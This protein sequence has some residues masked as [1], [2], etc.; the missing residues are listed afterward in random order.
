M[1]HRLA[2]TGSGFPTLLAGEQALHSRYNPPGEAEKYINNL[3]LGEG[4]RFFIL[5][6]PGLGYGIPPLRKRFPGAKIIALHIS[7]FS[8]GAAR[9]PG[10]LEPDAAWSPGSGREL[11]AFLEEEIPDTDAAFIRIVEWRPALTVYG[12]AYLRLLSE[13]A[14]FIKRIDAN[15]RTL[16]GFGR[17][18]FRN[19]FRNLRILGR[20]LRFSPGSV[21]VIITG[22]GPSL[23]KTLPL[24]REGKNK[25]P[26]FVLAV[27]SSVPALLAAGI[28]PDLI[29]STDGG[30]WT[31]FH[32]YE[33]IRGAPGSALAANLTAA[34]PSQCSSLPVLPISD[35]SLWQSLV[36]R[37]LSVPFITLPPRGTVTA[38][39][40]DLAFALTGGRI[41][42][43]GTD[44]AHR[45][46]RTHARPYSFD[47]FQDAAATRLNPRYSQGF[48]RARAIEAS[49]NHRIYAS[50]FSRQLAAYPRRLYSLG[51]NNPV[52]NGLS[53]YQEGA[54]G[55]EGEPVRMTAEN[56]DDPGEAASR[57]LL[58][59]LG[60]PRYGDI[61]TGE[62]GPLLFPDTPH[63][64]GEA[65][66][67]AAEALAKPYD[68]GAHG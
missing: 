57:V 53:P 67:E 60:H 48:L 45:D 27:S 14:E 21:P 1:I 8:P 28:G 66:R 47:R 61:L 49:G 32:L 64:A 33:T 6:E 31:L 39:A 36:L 62:L 37:S 63:P 4:I 9:V 13:T 17:R 12:E 11:Q 35:G 68:G 52:F 26:L 55:G 50:W 25:R 29:I 22:A 46:I 3:P 65:V 7:D 34:L 44:L 5:L 24:I 30:I 18:W 56:R 16:R 43:S 59:A 15:Q 20:T 2:A 10:G 54:G 41:F 23:E 40:L 51:I 42:I 38:S 19:M 58:R